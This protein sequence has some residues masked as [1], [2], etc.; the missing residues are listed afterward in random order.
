MRF[1]GLLHEVGL[2]PHAPEVLA[3]KV[4]V[5]ANPPRGAHTDVRLVR[6]HVLLRLRHHDQATLLAG[7]LHAVLQR[8]YTKGR[9]LYDLIWYL[10]DPDWP[11]PNLDLLNAALRQSGWQQ[12]TMGADTWRGAVR[13]RLETMDWHRAALDVGPFLENQDELALVTKANALRLLT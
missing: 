5:D 7:K 10:S 6:R 9:D 11:G 13:Q 12:G 2:S 4:E 3:V 1:P 8:G